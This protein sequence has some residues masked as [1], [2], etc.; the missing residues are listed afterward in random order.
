MF[1]KQNILH[2]SIISPTLF[3]KELTQLKLDTDSE[4]PFPNT[5]ENLYKFLSITTI[6]TF[7]IEDILIFSIQLPITSKQDFLLYQLIPLPNFSGRPGILSYV[8]P[9][10]PYML[11][12][13]ASNKYSMLADLSTCKTFHGNETICECHTIYSAATSPICEVMLKDPATSTIPEDC[14]TI[15]TR[16]TMEIWTPLDPNSWMFIVTKNLSATIVCNKVRKSIVICGT[17]ILTLDAQCKCYTKMVTLTPKTIINTKHINS[18]NHFIPTVNIS[19]DLCCKNKANYIE[20]LKLEAIQFKG[21]DINQLKLTKHKLEFFDNML[22]AELSKETRK[23]EAKGLSI[24]IVSI[25]IAGT[26]FAIFIIRTITKRKRTKNHNTQ[27]PI[28]LTVVNQTKE[29]I[30]ATEDNNHP[31]TNV[32][33]GRREFSL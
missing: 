19:N 2:P 27:S 28:N 11:I 1:A 25:I 29:D 20:N 12:D 33:S 15:T 21:T 30:D 17:G 23:Y 4:L 16:A 5:R 10:Q 26:T 18:H 24:A 13:A 6:K 31:E 3:R 22:Q 7:I 9:V 32:P 8:N 14:H